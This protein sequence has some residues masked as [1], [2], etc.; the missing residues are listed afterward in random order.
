MIIGEKI[1]A[2]RQLH[3]LTQ[4]EFAE[5]LYY[6]RQAV[7]RWENGE[8]TPTLETLQLI[9]KTFNIDGNDLLGTTRR[10]CQSCS[11]HVM[12][13]SVGT[14]EDLSVNLD[15][16]GYCY[17][18]GEFAYE[19]TLDEMVND[20][21]ETFLS[22][23]NETNQTSYNLNDGKQAF[24][25][26]LLTLKRWKTHPG[27]KPNPIKAHPTIFVYVKDS[28]AAVKFYKQVF[29]SRLIFSTKN[30]DQTY[31]MAGLD[32]YGF[33]V[34]VCER[35]SQSVGAVETGNVM[36]IN[37]H[38]KDQIR[39]IQRVYELLNKEAVVLQAPAVVLDQAY[40]FDLVDKFGVRWSFFDRY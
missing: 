25:N 14:N 28:V 16:C 7:S 15:Y 24:R 22:W 32:I 13:D 30:P 37:L 1:L 27:I 21:D 29:N 39:E 23:Y 17:A 4:E 5:K 18:G 9:A 3:Q 35:S 26:Q 38:L 8:T 12:I 10:T 19:T 6:T 36:Q 34:V 11:G 40:S 31:Q 20:F 2:I 33:E